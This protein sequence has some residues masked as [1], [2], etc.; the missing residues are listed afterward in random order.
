MLS[1]VVAFCPMIHHSRYGR[2]TDGR[3]G[4]N[5]GHR[6]VVGVDGGGTHLRVVVTD[7]SLRVLG[8][9][10]AGSANPSLVGSDTASQRVR[11]AI[12]QALDEAGVPPD[13]VE[14]ATLGIAGAS[15]AHSADWVRALGQAALPSAKIVTS[16][17]YEIA[18]AGANGRLEG[19][20]IAAGTGS[21]A[22]G[23]SSVGESALVGGWG[24]LL[25]DEGSGYWLGLEALRAVTLAE[26]GHGPRTALSSEV[27]DALGIEPGRAALVAWL[28][29]GEAPRQREVAGLA[30]LVLR[31]A[32]QG[33][34]A[35]EQ[36]VRRASTH[37][38]ELGRT[39]VDRLAL[40]DPCYVFAGS[41][42]SEANPLSLHLC[43][44]LGLADLPRPRHSPVLG[45]ALLA[46]QA[47]GIEPQ[48]ETGAD[49]E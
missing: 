8:S 41:L 6:L 17:D 1:I 46:L 29:R 35:S 11:D 28:Y 26:D 13:E 10:L 39:V 16:A 18:L 47:L 36:I 24:Y 25:G 15:V 9:G 33:E 22:Y 20:L 37:L 34:R 5:V 43:R 21:V 38:A 48:G 27:P 14:A 12:A 40:G 3:Q 7:E 4:G 44:E 32:E 2:H 49:R 23:V 19:V 31:L 42:L 45:A 30:P